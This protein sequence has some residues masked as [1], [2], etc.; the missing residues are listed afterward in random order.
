MPFF[1]LGGVAPGLT[2]STLLIRQW[3]ND[4]TFYDA[5]VRNGEVVVAPSALPPLTTGFFTFTNI[6]ASTEVITKLAQIVVMRMAIGELPQER[7]CELGWYDQFYALLQRCGLRRTDDER[8]CIILSDERTILDN[9]A[10]CHLEY[11]QR[12]LRSAAPST[13]G[14]SS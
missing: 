4:F 7:L 2:N 13:S 11:E 3:S 9:L 10:R 5:S 12:L 14:R 1:Q 6:A 8:P